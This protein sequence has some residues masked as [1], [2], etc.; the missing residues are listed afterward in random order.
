TLSNPIHD[1]TLHQRDTVCRAQIEACAISTCAAILKRA[2]SELASS[3][4]SRL[5]ERLLPGD[6]PAMLCGL[7]SER[8]QRVLQLHLARDDWDS[9]PVRW[10]AANPGADSCL[11][12]SI[13]KDWK[14]L[15]AEETLM[16]ID[17]AGSS[18]Q[19]LKDLT[20]RL[21]AAET[22]VL[23][24]VNDRLQHS[25]QLQK[26]LAK[27]SPML[28]DAQLCAA[29]A[30]ALSSVAKFGPLR[31]AADGEGLGESRLGRRYRVDGL[32]AGLAEQDQPVVATVTC[33][34][35]CGDVAGAGGGSD[36]DEAAI[37]RWRSG[38]GGL[39]NHLLLT[40]DVSRG[41][42]AV[43]RLLTFNDKAQL[44]A[45]HA[46]LGR[47]LADVLGG[48]D[49]LTDVSACEIV[50]GLCG[51]FAQLTESLPSSTWSLDRSKLSVCECG[52]KVP[53]RKLLLFDLLHEPAINFKAMIGKP[54]R[55]MLK[56]Q[57]GSGSQSQQHHLIL[58]DLSLL[59]LLSPG[60]PAECRQLLNL[61]DLK[62]RRSRIN[63]LAKVDTSKQA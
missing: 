47:P 22:A 18:K 36:V 42:L 7:S 38:L 51:A 19:I 34:W 23:S 15:T 2:A 44:C 10:Q 21:E 49:P 9:T 14:T 16:S 37:A 6:L 33:L 24:L 57:D 55:S 27:S 17:M 45:L 50:D 46:P 58:L 60:N 26:L 12:L 20:S 29:A 52:S 5:A 43:T 13:G 62:L 59:V 48:P 39:L 61:D 35:D 1:A 25:R 63:N 31:L 11:Q 32:Y 30:E 56:H 8:V 53:T 28:S 41:N 40:G 54:K 4:E 3:Y